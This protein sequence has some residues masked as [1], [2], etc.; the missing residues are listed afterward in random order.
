MV[1]RAVVDRGLPFGAR[2]L[3]GCA[4]T[5][6]WSQ[7]EVDERGGGGCLKRGFKATVRDLSSVVSSGP[8]RRR[9]TAGVFEDV[10]LGASEEDA[11]PMA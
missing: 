7:S 10:Q 11:T 4:R 1:D 2:I 3:V 6:R 5:R 9:A 8:A